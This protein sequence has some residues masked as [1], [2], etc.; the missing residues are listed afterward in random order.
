MA[1][2]WLVSNLIRSLQLRQLITTADSAAD[3]YTTADFLRLINETVRSKFVP[4][5]KRTREDYLITRETLTL[6]AGRDKYPLPKRAAAEALK[7][8]QYEAGDVWPP[9]DRVTEDTAHEHVGN[10]SAGAPCAFYLQDDSAVFV[11]VPA[12]G[13]S[14]RFLYYFRPSRVVEADEVGEITAIDTTTGQVTVKAWDEDAG[15]FSSTTPPATFTT[16]ATFDFVKGSPGFRCRAIN[17]ASSGVASNVLTFAA[18]DLPAGLEV[19]DFVCIA[20]ETPIA[21]LPAELHPVLAHEVSRVLLEA[22][23]DDK[24]KAAKETVKEMVTDAESMI[25]NRVQ[26]APKYVMNRNAPGHRPGLWRSGW[27][28]R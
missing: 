7:A 6:T 10:T 5:L 26:S 25:Q 16:S 12:G 19:G 15:A 13:E 9:L 18:A 17:L 28:W 22:K 2:E 8:I 14:I 23:G 11:P 21:Q 1:N 4:L 27:W 3:G 24:A 20:G